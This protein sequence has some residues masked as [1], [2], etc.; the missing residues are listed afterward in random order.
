MAKQVQASIAYLL[1]TESTSELSFE[2]ALRQNNEIYHERNRSILQT[3]INNKL[4]QWKDAD[5][6]EKSAT[7]NRMA[8]KAN[9]DGTSKDESSSDESKNETMSDSDEQASVPVKRH[10][11]SKVSTAGIYTLPQM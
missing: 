9:D 8:P 11:A 6:R 7:F 5:Q 2:Q 1:D 4:M 10:R 3:I